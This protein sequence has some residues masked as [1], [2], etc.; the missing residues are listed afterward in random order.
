M[1]KSAKN[2]NKKLRQG[3]LRTLVAAISLSTFFLGLFSLT[4]IVEVYNARDFK[5]YNT[6]VKRSGFRH[7][8]DFDRNVLEIDIIV[9]IGPENQA[10][11]IKDIYPGD[12]VITGNNGRYHSQRSI[13]ESLHPG[14]EVTV[15]CSDEYVKCYLRQGSY[16]APFTVIFSSLVWWLGFIYFCSKSSRFRDK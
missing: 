9:V 1:Q 11:T 6:V 15:Y 12:F 13:V 14:D 7:R 16:T 5:S 10:L 8:R 3:L 2:V 4:K